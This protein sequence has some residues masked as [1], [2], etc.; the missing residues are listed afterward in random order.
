MDF[1]HMFFVPVIQMKCDDWLTKKEKIKNIQCSFKDSQNFFWGESLQTNFYNEG[2][3]YNSTIQEIFYDEINKFKK[4]FDIENVK[5]F[6]SWFEKSLL[7]SFHGVHNHGPTG[8]SAVCYVDYCREMHKPLIFVS[9][10][11]YLSFNLL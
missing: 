9:P 8:Y 5:I 2:K 7:N 3:I 6:N 1:K 11:Q 4:I 10:F